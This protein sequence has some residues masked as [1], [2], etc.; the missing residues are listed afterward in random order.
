MT[1]K[2]VSHSNQAY[3]KLHGVLAIED[4]YSMSLHNYRILLLIKI[5]K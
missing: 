4:V 1:K 2:I 5:A 3:C